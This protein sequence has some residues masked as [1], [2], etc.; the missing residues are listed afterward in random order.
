V[1]RDAIETDFTTYVRARRETLVRAVVLLGCS[2]PEA[3]DLVQTALVRCYRSW[4]R[5]LAAEDSDA[6]VF[7][8]L[9]NCVSSSRSR[10]WVNERPTGLLPDEDDGAGQTIDQT[11]TGLAVREALNRLSLAHR[12]VLVLRYLADLSER[13]TAQVLGVPTG[14]VKSRTA[15]ALDELARDPALQDLDLEG[16]L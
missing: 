9:F 4:G 3:E 10:R 6:Y 2:V 11:V 1:E 13:Q 14:T 5:V 7:R 15:R 12:S 8:V 16:V